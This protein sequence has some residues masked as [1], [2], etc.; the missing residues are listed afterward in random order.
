MKIKLNQT[1]ADLIT[2]LLHNVILGEGDRYSDAAYDLMLAYPEVFGRECDEV[3]VK[4]K[5]PKGDDGYRSIRVSA[6][7]APASTW[8]F[9]TP[10]IRRY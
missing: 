10:K 9:H 3:P 8:P 2:A 6:K 5:F 7:E 4:V 1:Q